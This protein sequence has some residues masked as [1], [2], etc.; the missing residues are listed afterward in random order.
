MTIACLTEDVGEVAAGP[1]STNVTL[2]TV[3]DE[4]PAF[5]TRESGLRP[6]DEAYFRTL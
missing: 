5:Y 3:T 4:L 6:G 1:L 2:S